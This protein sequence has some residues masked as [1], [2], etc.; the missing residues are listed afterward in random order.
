GMPRRYYDY[1]PRFR[2]YHA[3]S[4]VGSWILAVGFLIMAYELLRSLRSGKRSPPNPWGS[5]GFEWQTSSPPIMQ[6]FVETPTITRGPY[7]YHLAT[8]AE[9]F[10]G[11]PDAKPE[12][13]H[14]RATPPETK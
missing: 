9:L 13:P 8:E 3:F 4:T 2:P 1:L 12:L 10:E 11:F 6:N 7:D 5:A 14:R